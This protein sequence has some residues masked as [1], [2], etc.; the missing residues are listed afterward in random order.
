MTL[1][2]ATNPLGIS[3][4]GDEILFGQEAVGIVR[5]SENGGKPET[6]VSV[7]TG[8]AVYGPQVLPGGQAV[9]FTLAAGA[10][11][12]IRD[13]DTADIVVQSLMSGE[14][15]I[16]VSDAV[17]RAPGR[18]S[19]RQRHYAAGLHVQQSRGR[20]SRKSSGPRSGI[21][22]HYRDAAGR[23]TIRRRADCRPG[24]SRYGR[25]SHDSGRG[26]LVRGAEGTR[27]GKVRSP[28]PGN[29]HRTAR[30]GT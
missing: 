3:W 27:A 11:R 20:T 9:L 26:A 10:T 8:E 23:Q 18:I 14:R 29:S 15:K 30:A 1:C 21:R 25:R 24:G 2:A 12:D 28:A 6:L 13:W 5:V 7:K 4:N 22:T 16:V 19:I 17:L